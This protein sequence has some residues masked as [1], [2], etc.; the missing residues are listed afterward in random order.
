MN[1]VIFFNLN[2]RFKDIKINFTK[3]GIRW[4]VESCKRPT[5]QTNA[6]SR[7]VPMV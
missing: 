3:E 4:G 6:L 5:Q 1:L 2:E 7:M